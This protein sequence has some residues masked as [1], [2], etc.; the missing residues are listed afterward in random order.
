MMQGNYWCKQ[1]VLVLVQI[2][3]LSLKS[4]ISKLLN[5]VS[6]IFLRRAIQ[7]SWLNLTLD[8]SDLIYAKFSAKIILVYFLCDLTELEAL[9]QGGCREH[10]FFILLRYVRPWI[11]FNFKIILKRKHFVYLT[12][13]APRISESWIKIKV[14]WSFYFHTS[15]C[16]LKR[17][18]EY[19]KG[20]HKT[21]WDT[22][23]KR[24]NK[25]LS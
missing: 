24:E 7:I 10:G 1:K 3:Y 12:L 23:K 13:P 9:K 22:T 11:V 18:Y 16:C 5:K 17:F 2:T 8:L 6:T 15:L 4:D 14:N 19:L 20:L 21:F 25:N